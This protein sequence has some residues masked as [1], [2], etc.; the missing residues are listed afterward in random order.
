MHRCMEGSVYNFGT[1]KLLL[2]LH[3]KITQEKLLCYEWDEPQSKWMLADMFYMKHANIDQVSVCQF[4][5]MVV[6][7]A[8]SVVSA[9]MQFIS[10]IVYSSP[11]RHVFVEMT[12]S[13]LHCN[14]R[15]SGK[16]SEYGWIIYIG[17]CRAE[18]QTGALTISLAQRVLWGQ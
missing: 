13:F 8:S 6:I 10:M 14:H 5:W 15:W 3:C 17:Y 9:L 2:L 18:G 7:E 1:K 4:H 12:S 11:S 16:Q